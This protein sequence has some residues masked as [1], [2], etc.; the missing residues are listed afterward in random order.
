MTACATVADLLAITDNPE[1]MG[2][3][4]IRKALGIGTDRARVVRQLA[5][6]TAQRMAANPFGLS[7]D[8]LHHARM[9][10]YAP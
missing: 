3:D 7:D 10:G 9:Q 6:D 4:Q 5:I 1:R 2:L 8:E